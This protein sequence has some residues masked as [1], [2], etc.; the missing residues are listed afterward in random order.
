MIAL[1]LSPLHPFTLSSRRTI[2][3][4]AAPAVSQTI[5]RTPYSRVPDTPAAGPVAERGSS[6][7]SAG[8][9]RAASTTL[10]LFPVKAGTG[11]KPRWIILPQLGLLPGLLPFSVARLFLPQRRGVPVI[12]PRASRIDATRIYNGGPAS[13]C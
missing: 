12:P 10:A 11:E 2:T 13:N 1:G 5:C 7:L 9:T 4:A 8:S 6:T 3:A